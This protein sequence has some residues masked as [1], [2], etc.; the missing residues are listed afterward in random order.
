MT[1]GTEED[2]SGRKSSFRVLHDDFAATLSEVGDG[3]TVSLSDTSLAFKTDAFQ[4]GFEFEHVYGKSEILF[5][6][7]LARPKA[8]GRS[9]P[10]QPIAD[11]LYGFE[12]H[13]KFDLF[14][15]SNVLKHGKD[16]PV[17]SVNISPESLVDPAFCEAFLAV[18]VRHGRD[19]STVVVEILE[20]YVDPARNVLHLEQLQKAGVRFALD[21]F[22]A[23]HKEEPELKS[24]FRRLQL[25][26]PYV[27][28]VKFDGGFMK[29]NSDPDLKDLVGVLKQTV[30]GVTIVAE[31]VCNFNRAQQLFDLGFDGA[32][33][34]KLREQ[35]LD[36]NARIIPKYSSTVDLD[37]S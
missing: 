19:P 32:Q 15:L 30:P 36:Y 9:F 31:H 2:K 7:A 18:L 8:L 16:Y 3:L 12:K 35:E 1:T 21:D 33:G 13:K 14:T 17:L 4:N 27:D 6:E 22:G 34:Q 28:I 5:T 24:H 23:K 20:H 10:I 37:L 29:G 26:R 11:T 25:F